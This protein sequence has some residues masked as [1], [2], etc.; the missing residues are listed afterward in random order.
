MP[1]EIV[2]TGDIAP[3]VG[4][5]APAVHGTATL[6]LSGQVGQHPDTGELI[7]TDAAE[8][9]RQVFRNVSAILRAAG[10]SL[11]DVLRV[12]LYLTTMDDFGPVNAVYG[13]VFHAPYPART[14]IAVLGLPKGALVEADVVVR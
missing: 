12:G 8:Q 6:Y 13:E 10:K 4:P 14:C 5:F 2:T 9:A 7:G 1:R 3:P 11:D